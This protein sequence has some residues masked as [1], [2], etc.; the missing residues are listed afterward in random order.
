MA[1]TKTKKAKKAKRAGTTK[2][3][4][5]KAPGKDA[6]QAT[7][8]AVRKARIPLLA[9]G[10]AIAGALGGV[11]LGAS[12]SGEK[13]MGVRLPGSK[14]VR[15]RSKDLARAAKEMGRFGESVGDLT[16]ELRSAREGLASGNGRHSSPIEVLLRGLTHRR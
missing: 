4:T 3:R 6:G 1:E 9:G 13:V 5:A 14:R 12:R 10:A 8:E 2:A 7:G 16:T 15:I 11:V